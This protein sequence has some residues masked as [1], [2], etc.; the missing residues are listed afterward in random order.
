M[1]QVI[2]IC[3]RKH[4]EQGFNLYPKTYPSIPLQIPLT[5]FT[6]LYAFYFSRQNQLQ[7]SAEI[8]LF[9]RILPTWR[10]AQ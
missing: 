9:V 2:E 7:I 4:I 10:V 6:Y 8:N 1:V 3:H 5:E